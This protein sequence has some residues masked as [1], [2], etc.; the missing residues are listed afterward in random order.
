MK[1]LIIARGIPS[2][3]HPQDGCFEWDQAKALAAKGHEIV[4]MSIDGRVRKY[5]RSPGIKKYDKDNVT[6]YKLFYFPTAIIRRLISFK[7]GYKIESMLAKRLY[8]YIVKR[9]GKFDIVHAHYLTTAYLGAEIKKKNDIKLVATEHW[10]ALKESVLTKEVQYLGDNS[11]PFVDSLISVSRHLGE[12]I[13]S[14]FGNDFYVVNNLIDTEGLQ[15]AVEHTDNS[16]YTIVAVGTL[17][18]IK[19]YDIL[20]RAFE[21]STLKNKNV[22]LKIIGNGPERANLEKLISDLS[23]SEKIILCGQ[24]P[25]SD[26]YNALHTADLYVLSSRSE[27]FPVALIEATANG[28]PAIATL[29]GGPQENKVSAVYKVP[30]ENIEA[31]A[32]ALDACYDEKDEI[33]RTAIQKETLSYYS[34]GVI[35]SQL[36]DIYNYTRNQA[37]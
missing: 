22:I 34:P 31:L 32:E 37:N 13:K 12:S 6:A 18:P 20:I 5:W 4:V 1:I 30:P 17:L 14:H 33:D 3:K 25:K 15:P 11:Y 19:G 2:D 23:L 8:R 28:V 35:A 24:L 27:N 9:H 36:I 29:C 7:L 16:H 21:K 26:V 10:S